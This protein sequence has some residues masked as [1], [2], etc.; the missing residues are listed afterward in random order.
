MS[1][2]ESDKLLIK[3]VFSKWYRIPEYQ[4]P[5][6]WG[7]EQISELLDDINDAL[8]KDEDSQYFLGSMVLQKNQTP[9][10]GITFEE[11]DV[12]DGQQRLTTLF[13]LIA[14]LRD[15]T[16]NTDVKEACQK[17]IFQKGN[18]T[19]RIPERLRVVFDIREE[20]KNFIIS[21]VKDTDTTLYITGNRIN[22]YGK[23]IDTSIKNMI[24]NIVFIKTYLEEKEEGYIDKL[25]TYLLNNVLMIYV[26]SE[27]LDDAFRLFTV[28]N[29][30]GV[31]LRGSDILKASNL[32]QIEDVNTRNKY[33]LVWEETE[34]YFEENFDEF[35]SHLRSII[36]KKKAASSLLKEFE[37]NI[38]NPKEYDR[39]NKKTH[40][41]PPLLKKGAETFEFIKRYKDH[42]TKIFDEDHYSINNSFEFD[43]LLTVMKY[44]LESDSWVAPLLRFYDKFKN[45]D[46]I[47]FTKALDNMFA[48]DW[49]TGLTPTKRIENIHSILEKIDSEAEPSSI[50]SHLKSHIIKEELSTELDKKIYGRRPARYLMLKLDALMHGN[51]RKISFP[52]TISI[53]HILPQTPESNSNWLTDFCDEEKRIHYTHL[54]GNLVLISRRKNSSQGNKDYQVKKEKYFKGNIELFSNSIRIYLKYSTWTPDALEHNHC[55]V[56]KLLINSFMNI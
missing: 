41:L 34:N 42:Y 11:Y 29:N 25:T 6:V 45:K 53:E 52:P 24:L 43:N 37:D 44:G 8:E 35:L 10:E 51:E 17:F 54:L 20:V 15:L 36:V 12:L 48:F 33:A 30:R 23:D 56:K 49:I 7:M 39:S 2:I 21:H 27:N 40:A 4:R 13:L 1:K 26:S 14:V 16:S 9:Q 32:S 3:D 31:K 5:Y 38:Y 18:N 47:T 28:M 50:I 46:L 22:E 19:L 55:Y